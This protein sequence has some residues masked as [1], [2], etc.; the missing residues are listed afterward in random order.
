MA[1]T[2]SAGGCQPPRVPKHGTE[3]ASP[4]RKAPVSS[5][6]PAPPKRD[7]SPARAL[8]FRA[9]GFPTVDAP[10]IED[11]VL[12]SAL[13]GIDV[14][15]AASITELMERLR[16]SKFDVLVL[17]YG[18]AFPVDA[19][20]RIQSFLKDG[21]GLAVLG[22]APLH[23]PVRWERNAWVRGPRQ[24][25]FAH[26]LLI[27]PAEPIVAGAGYKTIATPGQAAGFDGVMPPGTKTWALTLRLTHSKEFPEEH[28]SAG[29]RDAV[30][31]PLAHVLDAS[32][33]PR[34][35][36]LL[37]I[38]HFGGP[39]NG[40][41]WVFAT[42]DAK[43]DA[44][45]VR[46][47]VFRAMEG[48]TE[49]RVAPER[50]S[51]A[52]GQ[53][54]E[55]VVTVSHPSVANEGLHLSVSDD[56]GKVVFETRGR[57]I[58]DDIGVMSANIRVDATLAPGLYHVELVQERAPH[59]GGAARHARTGFWVRDEKLL[60]S[61]P[62]LTVSR[63]FLRKDGHPFPIVGTTY[64]AS[65][66]HRDFL[67]QPNP[68][69]WD[70]DFAEMKKRGINFVRTG[71]WTAWSRAMSEPGR[72]DEDV[73]A[74]L[75]AFVM[76]AAKHDIVVCFN[77]FAFL[78]P[79]WGGT[80]PYLDPL[81]IDAQKSFVT[82]FASRMK[83]VG[84]IHWDLINEPSYAPRE[85]L[86]KTRPIGDTFEAKAWKQWVR[87]QHQIGDE[88]DGKLR[89]IWHTADRD[90]FAVPHDEDFAQVAMQ[91]D[92]QPRKARDFREFSEDVIAGWAHT[93]RTAI[94]A[95][96]GDVLVTL[97]QDEGG[98]WE[99]A[100]QQLMAHA[101]DYTAVHTWWKND[102]LL[103]DG[104]LTKVAGKPSLH[105]ETGLMRL[106]DIDGNPWR[107][108]ENAAL[109]LERKLGYA[110]AGRAAGV[111][112]WVW[113]ENPYMPLDEEATI[114]LFRPDG[115]AKPELDEMEKLASFVK[116]TA[117]HFDDFEPDPVILV[118]PHARAF[119][120]MTSALDASKHVVRALSERYGVVPTAISDLRLDVDRLKGAKLVI[121]PSPD[122]LD[123]RAAK[124][125][126][127]A[128]RGGTKVL[129]TGA[130][131]GDSYGMETPSLRALG[132]LGPSRPVA[133]ME[134]SPW[135]ASGWVAF[136]GLLQ[137][138]A[139]RADTPSLSGPQA[140][141]TGSLWHEPLPLELARDREPL[142]KLLGAAL[143]A[144]KVP[145]SPDGGG[146][147]GRVLL[148]PKTAL[149]VA[150]NER[151]EPATRKL[152]VD[153]RALDLPVRARGAAMALVDR[154]TGKI[155]GSF[156]DKR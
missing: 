147:A 2:L 40:A 132:L 64:M 101:L 57:L 155:L 24:T 48:A 138:S 125:L 37:E 148:A 15:R 90:P 118:I 82:A 88:G 131:Q 10:P 16:R 117:K 122:V 93:M 4:H 46:A 133:M 121:V 85:K 156:D 29:P 127:K 96:G 45:I 120:G 27:G 109:L 145:T 95:A 153:G 26:D 71:L 8:L 100:S 104:V 134:K 114:G 62:T 44:P 152:L 84:W 54:A 18:S 39:A 116:A 150:V 42:T 58:Q 151:P 21:G 53:Q 106:E 22:G 142:V 1:A 107:S 105:Q 6:R 35:C 12:E 149:A 110:F 49:L 87:S 112:E 89:A 50:A 119:L 59:A 111:V 103:W 14:V 20:P 43:L 146:V 11:K 136:E 5:S 92:K 67:F 80:N 13:T 139:R 137:E 73:L 60:G 66:V 141:A 23:E 56:T 75:D 130:I 76:T 102:D 69:L 115:T 17:P 154:A 97:G 7:T 3:L 128:S 63:D 94:R 19:W 126:L 47:I 52:P 143:A 86:W 55:L 30:A 79:D 68:H 91:I 34:G 81:A 72:V 98:L 61:G 129:V 140:L 113:N 108:P 124:A 9:D 28:G 51:I 33:T 36:P 38:D 65:D 144:A 99:R 74:A 77:F 31:R 123:E 78:P 135:S 32:G 83:N 70:A 41:R 25:S